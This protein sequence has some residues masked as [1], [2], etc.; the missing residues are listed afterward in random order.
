MT[1]RDPLLP[2]RVGG[3]LYTPALNTGIV[4]KIREQSIPQLHSLVLCLEDSVED[5]ALD[6]AERE[7][8]RTLLRLER[9]DRLP[10]LFV[11]VRSPQHLKRLHRMLG[12]L[13][14]LLCGYV[15]PKFD[16][17]NAGRYI[18]LLGSF[19]AGR[20]KKLTL[21]PILE[22]GMVAGVLHR[23]ENLYQIKALLE[24]EKEQILNV[25][26][27]GND[28]CH[29]FAI[30]RH[31]DQTIY[32]IGVI[33]DILSDIVNIFGTDYVVSG[34]V[35]EYFGSDPKGAWAE[36]L[37]REMALD[38]LNGF[39]GKTA[40]HPAQLPVIAEC[41]KPSRT[42]WE[43]AKRILH[44]DRG[45]MAV[46]KSADGGRMNEQKCHSRWARKIMALGEIYG[47]AEERERP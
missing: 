17:S 6:E 35:W 38:L 10:L 3:L 27:G 22:S 33:R 4:E 30:R 23:R 19:N 26:V 40:I 20:E 18:E 16:L 1:N 29:L 5:E 25:R 15:L 21:M 36:G 42:D 9:C 32:E 12:G 34:P 7:L 13:S 39:V 31:A 43:D 11:R 44:W 28:F 37:R 14:G 8:E 47:V 2:Y 46:Q 41:L 45:G 24:P